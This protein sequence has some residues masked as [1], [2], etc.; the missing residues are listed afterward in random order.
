MKVI[1]YN[2]SYISHV[3]EILILLQ[4]HECSIT[5]TRVPASDIVAKGCFEDLQRDCR[6]KE[7]KIL[8]G[9]VDG[10]YAGF[11]SYCFESS[12]NCHEV[13]DYKRY[14]LITSICL[15]PDFRHKGLG[16]DLL[17]AAEDRIRAAG[18]RGRLR[19]CAVA[20]NALA[21]LAYARFGFEPKEIVFEKKIV[22]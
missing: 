21:T 11:V 8:V 7:G 17:Q 6:I 5:D 12:D 4:E 10:R 22:D 15:H 1:P 18:F 20:N 13:S 16:Q 14:A 9:L 19:I 2:R 3:L